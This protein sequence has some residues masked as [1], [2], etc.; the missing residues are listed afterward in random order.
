MVNIYGKSARGIELG[1]TVST[2]ASSKFGREYMTRYSFTINSRIDS[3]LVSGTILPVLGKF[4]SLSVS[5]RIVS[6]R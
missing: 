2:N 1:G 5:R 6:T 4:S 3:M